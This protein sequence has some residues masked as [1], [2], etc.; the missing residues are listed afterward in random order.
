MFQFKAVLSAI[1]CMHII[2]RMHVHVKSLNN[3]SMIAYIAA[4]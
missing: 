1:A 2:I 3:I 4:F